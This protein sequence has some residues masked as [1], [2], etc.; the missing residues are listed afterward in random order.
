M[1]NLLVNTLGGWTTKHV[2]V[3][4]NLQPLSLQESVG[5]RMRQE[6]QRRREMKLLRGK[7]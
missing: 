6:L 7:K 1:M 3:D 4:L 2:S 5:L